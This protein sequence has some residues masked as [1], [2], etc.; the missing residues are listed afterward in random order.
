[1]AINS[2]VATVTFSIIQNWYYAKPINFYRIGVTLAHGCIPIYMDSAYLAKMHDDYFK[3][4]ETRLFQNL[5]YGDFS[6]VA[7]QSI[8]EAA[9]YKTMTE[10]A[11]AESKKAEKLAEETRKKAEVF[12]LVAAITNSVYSE[13]GV[14][15]EVA[16]AI[17]VPSV[18]L[19]PLTDVEK[20]AVEKIRQ[21]LLKDLI[22]KAPKETL[23]K[24]EV[25]IAF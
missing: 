21:A 11:E 14:K 19:V 22:K 4:R 16:P 7:S 10:K 9:S 24:P 1:M 23:I 25:Q 18:P 13:M 20:T 17:G 3:A 8:S 6:A 2:L 5:T 15:Q 12:R